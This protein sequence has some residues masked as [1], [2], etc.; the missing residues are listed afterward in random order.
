MDVK[1]NVGVVFD[2]KCGYGKCYKI[3]IKYYLFL[4]FIKK[5]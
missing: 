1:F 5:N 4:D 3:D 2:F